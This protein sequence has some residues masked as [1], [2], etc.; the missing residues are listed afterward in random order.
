MRPDSHAASAPEHRSAQEQATALSAHD[1]TCTT[2]LHP[3]Y[4]ALRR[5][6][7][8]TWDPHRLAMLQA[9]HS[10]M[11]LQLDFCWQIRV[12]LSLSKGISSQRKYGY[13]FSM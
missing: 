2:T 7:T 1:L 8:P 11:C 12:R 3:H 6:V 9:F 13:I 5:P 4:H 10:S